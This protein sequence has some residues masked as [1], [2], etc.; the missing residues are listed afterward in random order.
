MDRFYQH[1]SEPGMSK[2]EALQKAQVEI[3]AET[4]FNHPFFWSTFVLV[5]NWM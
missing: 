2:A 5:G 1:L 3:I 4:D